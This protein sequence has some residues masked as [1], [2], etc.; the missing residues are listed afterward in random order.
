MW[1][2]PEN[3]HGKKTNKNIAKDAEFGELKTEKER[4]GVMTIETK[5]EGTKL[6]L[7]LW[8][9][10]DTTTAPRLEELLKQE[11]EGVKDLQMDFAGVEYISSAGLRVLLYASKTMK[12]RNGKLVIRNAG[13]DV[14]EVFV[15]TGFADR[16]TIEN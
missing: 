1:D 16:L 9:R 3:L 8:G 5:K 7:G 15:I 4:V 11:T 12:G 10:L 13:K 14:M 2:L 6:I